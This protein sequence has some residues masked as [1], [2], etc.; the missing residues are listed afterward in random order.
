MNYK[1][2]TCCCKKLKAIKKN[3]SKQVRGKFG[4]T[5]RCKKC[6]AIYKK[7]HYNKVKKSH[8]KK[9][10]LYYLNNRERI[11]KKKKESYYELQSMHNM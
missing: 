10:K 4:F 11:L 8:N 3:F 6:T 7:Q 9:C 2:C 5:A 1:V